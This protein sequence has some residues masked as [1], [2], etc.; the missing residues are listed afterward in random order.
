VVEKIVM[1]FEMK[2]RIRFIEMKVQSQF[3]ERKVE[4][5]MSFVCGT[6]WKIDYLFCFVFEK[7]GKFDFGKFDRLL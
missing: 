3:A 2:V 1:S 7:V 4:T 6:C 5:G